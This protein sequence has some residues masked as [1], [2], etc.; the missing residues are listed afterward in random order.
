MISKEFA[1]DVV[2]AALH[3]GASD[4][5]VIIRDGDEFSVTVRMGEVE[6]IKNVAAKKL[7]LRVFSG[8]RSA[9]TSTANLVWT[10]VEALISETLALAKITSEDPVSGLPG[11]E[12]FSAGVEDVGIFHADVQALTLE[13]R[14]DM[15]RRVEKAALSVDP[16]ILNS[17]GGEFS[18]SVGTLVLANSR[19][20][21]GE[22]RGTSASIVAV[23]IASENGSMQ[24]DYWFS[25]KRSAA[26]LE[27]PEL[28][29]RKAAERALR[30]LGARSVKTQAVPVVFDSSMAASLIG[31]LCDAVC[32]SAIFR[33]SSFLVDKLGE[34][35]ASRGVS[36]VDDGRLPGG[37]GSRP[38]DGEGLPS[39]V[40][41][42]IENGV[43]V[44]YL[45]DTYSAKKLSLQS[46]GNAAR[47]VSTP[48]SVGPSNFYLK[49]GPYR[50]EEI[51]RS[52]SRGLYL[53]EMI[54][55]G[56]NTVNGD[57]SQGAVG[58]WIENGELAFP[59]EEI[60]IAGNL[61]DMFKNIEMIGN[62]LEF[63]SA[64][65]APTLKIAEMVISGQ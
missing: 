7:G 13:A 15:A 1:M 42:V 55:F 30:R 40:T 25:V 56:V 58:L 63:R 48:P 11:A 24:R 8:R 16:R 43:L 12:E 9:I 2:K 47:G 57:F 27:S 60:T 21:A 19:G 3:K 54:G 14:I 62:D 5:D 39:R 18:N 38:F 17:E 44:N 35:I 34:T 53:T 29:G 46:T 22:Y 59:V 32:G 36:I 50:P 10:S 49:A 20:F 26:A 45:L 65:A 52:V 28:V 64:I 6:T 23:P 41:P 33:K 61:L 37:L 51:I 4:A 31:T